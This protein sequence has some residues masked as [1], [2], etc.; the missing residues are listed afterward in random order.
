M[1][2]GPYRKSSRI[3]GEVR[4]QFPGQGGRSAYNALVRMAQDFSLRYLL[5]DGQ[6]NFGSIHGDPGA[7]S[8][9]IEARLS[10]V[11]AEM[12]G[13]LGQGP[14]DSGGVAA[15]LTVLPSNFPNL[16]AN[17]SWGTTSNIPPHNLREVVSALLHLIDHPDATATELATHIKGPDFPTGGCIVGHAGIRE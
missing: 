2:N 14:L 13:G 1:P 8:P 10:P 17:G 6:G 16:L 12:L 5:V 11:G 15:E 4:Q 9:Y 3:I 7:A